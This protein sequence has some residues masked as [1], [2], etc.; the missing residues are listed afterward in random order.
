VGSIPE[1][2]LVP[3][4]FKKFFFKEGYID[5]VIL[6]NYFLDNWLNNKKN[7]IPA[8]DCDLAEGGTREAGPS[9]SGAGVCREHLYPQLK[10]TVLY[11]HSN[12]Q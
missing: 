3:H 8:S 9:A 11:I 1:I 6:V 2:G 5:Q 12:T 7:T 4:L 10:Y